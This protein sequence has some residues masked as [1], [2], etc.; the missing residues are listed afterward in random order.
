MARKRAIVRRLPYEVPPTKCY[1]LK[2]P[3]ELRN[4]IYGLA[5]LKRSTVWATH[6]YNLEVRQYDAFTLS[7]H[8]AEPPLTRVNRE[9]RSETLPVYYAINTFGFRPSHLDHVT[10]PAPLGFCVESSN[11]DRSNVIGTKSLGKLAPFVRYLKKIEI[12]L[13]CCHGF[14]YI[15]DLFDGT[16]SRRRESNPCAPTKYS[17][18]YSCVYRKHHRTET[19]ALMD[20]V[21]ARKREKGE[22]WS[23]TEV[24][25]L[26]DICRIDPPDMVSDSN[27][28]DD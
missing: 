27:S 10:I 14:I 2:L 12:D 23:E 18:V 24:M 7:M 21:T 8:N 5:L 25:E 9:I 6:E 13:Q 22:G 11:I 15:A 4:Y 20:A 26:I 28:D 19:Q 1:L 17:D 16:L 3:A